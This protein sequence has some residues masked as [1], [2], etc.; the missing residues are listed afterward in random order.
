MTRSHGRLSWR[1]VVY[2]QAVYR[3]H[4]DWLAS[5]ALFGRRVL[6]KPRLPFESGSGAD[7]ALLSWLIGEV[8]LRDGRSAQAIRMFDGA[9]SADS[10]LPAILLSRATAQL[11]AGDADGAA[12][13][14]DEAARKGF[15]PEASA[16]RSAAAR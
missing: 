15:A 12:R 13:S 3:R 2:L 14:L 4:P 10:S 6:K 7:P 16:L 9:L 8:L 1:A 5:P 11:L